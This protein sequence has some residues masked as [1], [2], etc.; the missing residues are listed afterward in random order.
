[1]SRTALSTTIARIRTSD[2]IPDTGQVASRDAVSAGGGLERVPERVRLV[3]S[4]FNDEPATTLQRYAHDD[5]AALLG[6]LQRT[7]ARPRLHRRHVV[8]PHLAR[9]EVAAPTR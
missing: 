2:A 9:A 7:I 1:P 5:A 8:S 3:G 6:D 4:H